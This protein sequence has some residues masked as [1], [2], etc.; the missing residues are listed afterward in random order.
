MST[1]YYITKVSLT[2][3]NL[4]ILDTVRSRHGGSHLGCIVVAL[5]KHELI[6]KLLAVMTETVVCLVFIKGFQVLRGY[7]NKKLIWK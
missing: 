2:I 1:T 6:L 7:T 5:G 4:D 3:V